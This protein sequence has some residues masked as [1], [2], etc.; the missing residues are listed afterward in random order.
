MAGIVARGLSKSFS[1][2]S[3][4]RKQVVQAISDVSLNIDGT[5]FTLLGPSGCGK[6]TTLR[7]IAG[8]ERPDSGEIYIGGQLVSSSSV[9]VPPEKRNLGMVFQS[10]AIWPHMTVFENIAY[11]LRLRKYDKSTI[12]KMVNEVLEIVRLEG[13]E[14]RPATQLSG[15]Q[16]QRV[17]LARALVYKPKV[18]LLDEPLSNLDAKLRYYM[19]SELRELLKSL[20]ITTVYVTH[21]QSEAL[22]ISDEVA[23]MNQGK[24]LEKGNPRQIYEAPRHPFVAEFIGSANFL[25]GRVDRSKS[26]VY[27][28]LGEMLCQIPLD[29]DDGREAIICIRPEYLTVDKE[30]K[31]GVNTFEGRIEKIFFTPGYYDCWI[32]MGEEKLNAHV[33]ATEPLRVGEPVYV[34]IN[35][36]VIAFLRMYE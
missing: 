16:Q 7:C 13:M 34:H 21:D 22:S 29:L 23:V 12:K 19:R 14:N 6:S 15:G 26:V 32:D 5:I 3:G 36:E 10:Y 33:K 27:T 25:K 1:I 28:R 11:P 24:I 17:A 30:G 35:P 9:F 4:N 2:R 31:K 20:G 18:L 8:L